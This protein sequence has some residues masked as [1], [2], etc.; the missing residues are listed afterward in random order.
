M[1]CVLVHIGTVEITED[2]VDEGSLTASHW[3]GQHVQLDQLDHRPDGLDDGRL[4]HGGVLEQGE[5]VL[6]G[7]VQSFCL[8]E[9]WKGYCVLLPHREAFAKFSSALKN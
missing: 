1:F 3:L 9:S 4:R 5:G 8:G 2:G 6:D 7:R